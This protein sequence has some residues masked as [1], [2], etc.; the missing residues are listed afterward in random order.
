MFEY[1]T[2]T[3]THTRLRAGGLGNTRR[4]TTPTWI[5]YR[6][7]FN[8]LRGGNTIP[9]H[10]A[11]TLFAS[12][13][14][15]KYSCL[16][17]FSAVMRA[18]GSNVNK[19]FSNVHT[20]WFSG[21]RSI[22]ANAGRRC[23]EDD[24]AADTEGP[25][26]SATLVGIVVACHALHSGNSGP[27]GHESCAVIGPSTLDIACNCIKFA[28]SRLRVVSKGIANNGLHASSSPNTQP[29]A[30]MSIAGV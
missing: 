8:A 13:G 11:N 14:V 9:E 24:T 10:S 20:C 1:T 28:S 18:F 30:H 5:R 2:H 6:F 12:N 22:A 3:H 7:R 16:V 23:A 4:S 19:A 25:P 17:A 15:A 21:G 26:P 27:T 29:M